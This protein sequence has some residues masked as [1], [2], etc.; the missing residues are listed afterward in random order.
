MS[1]KFNYSK[2]IKLADDLSAKRVQN[3]AY[4]SYSAIVEDLRELAIKSII[5]D[6]KKVNL[7]NTG[8]IK[9]LFFISA[10]N[11]IARGDPLQEIFLLVKHGLSV[12]E[13]PFI[14]VISYIQ[15]GQ[16]STLLMAIHAGI[17]DLPNFSVRNTKLAESV[18]VLASFDSMWWKYIYKSQSN[19]DNMHIIAAMS[20][21]DFDF[22]SLP[23]QKNLNAWI[24]RNVKY[25]EKEFAS[26]IRNTPK[27]N[28]LKSVTGV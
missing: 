21:I 14:K 11:D 10:V 17:K 1:K 9:R 8:K 13:L 27:E 25:N 15:D 2:Y 20:N 28:Y 24:R 5:R 4:T 18:K 3:L 19:I 6:N 26:L 22:S 7:K 12:N 16:I 23:D